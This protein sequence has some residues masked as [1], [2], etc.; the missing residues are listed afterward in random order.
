RHARLDHQDI[1]RPRRQPPAVDV[2]FGPAG[3]HD[4]RLRIGMDMQVRSLAGI[5]IDIKER[6]GR[7][8]F[9][10]LEP[11]GAALALRHF[12]ASEEM[13][14]RSAPLLNLSWRQDIRNYLCVKINLANAFA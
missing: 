11:H 1:A 5:V 6:R 7:A 10:A 13:K 9:L 4:P 14:H 3:A 12:F 8:V 2:E